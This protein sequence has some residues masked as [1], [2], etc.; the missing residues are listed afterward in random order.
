MGASLLVFKNKSDIAGALGEDVI[1]KVRASLLI[2][3]RTDYIHLHFT[4][5]STRHAD[6]AT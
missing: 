3:L 2:Q 5:A 1:R 4:L 6:L